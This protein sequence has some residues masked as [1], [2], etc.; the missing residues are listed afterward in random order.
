MEEI[1]DKDSER[2]KNKRKKKEEKRGIILKSWCF[3]RKQTVLLYI[4]NTK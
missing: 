3:Y 2:G 4:I 1:K